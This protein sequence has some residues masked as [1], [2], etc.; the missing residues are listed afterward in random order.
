MGTRVLSRGIFRF[1]VQSGEITCIVTVSY[2]AILDFK[3]QITLRF[4]DRCGAVLFR[5]ILFHADFR[6]FGRRLRGFFRIGNAVF[7]SG[8]FMGLKKDFM[9][10]KKRIYL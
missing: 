4:C 2:T 9:G 7:V 6:R 5:G 3:P 8:D 10:F 1:G